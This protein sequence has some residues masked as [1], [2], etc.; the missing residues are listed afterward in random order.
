ML[1]LSVQEIQMTLISCIVHKFIPVSCVFYKKYLSLMRLYYNEYRVD[2][3]V[4]SSWI[5]VSE[6]KR[7]M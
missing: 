2:I 5:F 3:T 7:K 1:G 4:A 6:W